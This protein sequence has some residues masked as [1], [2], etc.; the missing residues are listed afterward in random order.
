MMPDRAVHMSHKGICLC[1]AHFQAS[2]SHHVTTLKAWQAAH[3]F[4]VH[5]PIVVLVHFGQNLIHILVQVTRQSLQEC[6]TA[7]TQSMLEGKL[8]PGSTALEAVM[9]N[10]SDRN[11]SV[12]VSQQKATSAQQVHKNSCK[13]G[14]AHPQC[15]FEL[16]L[17]D[18]A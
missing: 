9:I 18:R 3:L 5:F 8:G 7:L 1:T 14:M 11:P 17:G 2:F 16:C 12:M 6:N 15:F 4:I 13:A 10:V